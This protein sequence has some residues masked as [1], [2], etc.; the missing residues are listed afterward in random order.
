MLDRLLHT[1]KSR[2]NRTAIITAILLIGTVIF[3]TTTDD[4]SIRK[5]SDFVE[6][7]VSAIGTVLTVYFRK[8]P[9]VDYSDAA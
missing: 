6:I 1:L 9:K 8:N 2:T 7:I 4:A 3:G 5:V